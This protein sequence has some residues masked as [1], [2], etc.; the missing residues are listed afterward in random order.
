MYEI[1]VTITINAQ[2][3]RVFDVITDHGRF[4]RGP[5]MTCRLLAEGRNQKNGLGAVREV[6]TEGAVF[7]EEITAFDPPRHFEY[8][9]RHL[10][11]RRG[12]PARLRHERG[13]LDFLASGETTRVDWY[14]RFEVTIPI[15]GW[16][17]ERMVGPRAATGF[18]RLLDQAKTELEGNLSV[19]RGPRGHSGLLR[20]S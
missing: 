2:P 7:T 20:P 9:V 14:S 4:F 15:V 1:H 5:S 6:T 19:D 17:A 3:Q 10:I 11:D 8:V 13:W 18:R 12:K 16:F